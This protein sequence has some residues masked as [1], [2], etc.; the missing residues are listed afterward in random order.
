M[1]KIVAT[2]PGICKGRRF[3]PGRSLAAAAMGRTLAERDVEL[4]AVSA[5]LS[6]PRRGR[7]W[8]LKP[9]TPSLHAVD[10]LLRE[11]L[12][13]RWH[14]R[15]D[16]GVELRELDVQPARQILE[17]RI[18]LRGRLAVSALD[19]AVL[20]RRC[21]INGCYVNLRAAGERRPL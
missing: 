16:D 19:D 10:L 5:S 14:V 2:P 18:G 9:R 13:Q 6:T 12:V 21:P 15:L 20:G 17:D 4:C 1:R 8:G 3:A 7:D 11:L